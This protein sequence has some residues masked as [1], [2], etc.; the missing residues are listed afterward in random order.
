MK[1]ISLPLINAKIFHLKFS[2]NLFK[3]IVFLSLCSFL[4]IFSI[5]IFNLISLIKLLSSQKEIKEKI[6][7]VQKEI[8]ALQAQLS[9]ENLILNKEEELENLGFKRVMPYQIKYLQ[10]PP[11]IF[12]SK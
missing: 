12:V 4:F 6:F 3:K 10:V 1:I 11:E 9:K 7:V 8:E 5:F 2:K